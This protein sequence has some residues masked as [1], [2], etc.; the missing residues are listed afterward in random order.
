[1]AAREYEIIESKVT[2][3]SSVPTEKEV[4]IMGYGRTGDTKP[5][6]DNFKIAMGSYI[7]NQD[8]MNIEFWDPDNGWKAPEA[9]S[10]Q[11]E[12]SDS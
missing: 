6:E 10:T 12:G 8:N 11:A 2:K 5:T 9:A 3:E 1:M 7:V 4:W